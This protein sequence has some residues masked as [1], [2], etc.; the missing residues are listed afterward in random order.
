MQIFGKISGNIFCNGDYMIL[1]KVG[2]GNV[3][4]HGEILDKELLQYNQNKIYKKQDEI[5]IE[6]LR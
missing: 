1:G 6:E 4:F 5:M 3:L 2:E